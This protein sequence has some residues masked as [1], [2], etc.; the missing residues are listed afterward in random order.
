MARRLFPD[1]DWHDFNMRVEA[2]GGYAL[3]MHCHVDPDTP[4]EEAHRLAE[5]VETQ[6][7]AAFPQLHRVTIH[8]EPTGHDEEV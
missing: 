6:M 5:I 1:K 3:S 8:T 7:R 4:L 2:D